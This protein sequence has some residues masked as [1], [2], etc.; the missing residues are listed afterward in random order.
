MQIFMYNEFQVAVPY[1]GLVQSTNNITWN[2]P[3]E[4]YSARPLPPPLPQQ[5]D[6]EHQN[7]QPVSEQNNFNPMQMSQ[8]QAQ[9]LFS[10]TDNNQNID[11]P[12]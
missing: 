9:L 10:S 7:Q 5:V 4:M 3:F 2:E 12:G 6:I 11:R 8:H 1:N